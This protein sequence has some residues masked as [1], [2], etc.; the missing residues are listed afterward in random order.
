MLNKEHPC[1]KQSAG[2]KSAE[3]VRAALSEQMYAVSAAKIS[4]DGRIRLSP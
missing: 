2:Y 1:S 3:T 4:G